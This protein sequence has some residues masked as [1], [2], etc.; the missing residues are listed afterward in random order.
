MIEFGKKLQALRKGMGLTQEELAQA[1]YVSR[2]AVSK[3]ESGRGYPSIDSLKAISAYFSVSV[4]VLL[5]GEEVF[6]LAQ[7]DQINRAK[8]FRERM[9]SLLDMCAAAFLFIPLFGQETGGVVKPVPL[10]MLSQI[11]PY[12]KALY[13]FPGAALMLLGCTAFAL[14]H[15]KRDVQMKHM[16]TLSL[17]LGALAVL[18]FIMGRQAYVAGIAFLL[19]MMKIYLLVK[20]R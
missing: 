19:L 15:S 18:V 14:L 2:T 9:L 5:S 16:P 20:V 11:Q 12:M 10:A 6:E 8:G 3:W 1:L 4:D 13:I 17:L 7:E